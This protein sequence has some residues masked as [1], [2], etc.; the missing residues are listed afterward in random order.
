MTAPECDVC[1]VGAGVAGALVAYALGRAGISTVVLEAGRR[2]PVEDRPRYMARQLDWDDPWR[3]DAP[4]RDVYTR[5]GGVEYDLN[6]YRVKAVGGSTMHWVGYT[7]RFHADDFAMRTR[8]GVAEDWPVRYVDLEPWYCEAEAELAVAGTESPFASP[9]SCPYP[10][11]AFPVGYDEGLLVQAGRRIGIDFHP[12]PQARNSAPYDGRPQC[13]TFGTC[14]TCPIRVR[15]SADVHVEL[16]EA[17]GRVTVI[18]ESTVVRL[19]TGGVNGGAGA[20][21]VRRAI[22][23]ASDGTEHACE[24]EAFVVAAHAVESARLLLL[25]AQPG[26]PDGLANGSGTAGR[27]FMEHM[28]QFRMAELDRNLHPHRKGFATVFSQQY[29][30][31]STRD[32]ESGFLLRDNAEGPTLDALLRSTIGRSGNWGRA[33]ESELESVVRDR[34]GRTFL[35]GSNAEPLPSPEN[36]VE[37]D[38]EVRVCFGNPAPRITYAISDYERTAYR[39]ADPIIHALADELGARSLGDMQNHFGGHQAGTCRM[40]DDPDASVVDRQL[41][42]HEVENLYVVGSGNFVT[43]S[44]VNP[45][46]T[47]A[48]L[49]LRL[50][51]HLG[52]K[53]GARRRTA[54]RVAPATSPRTATEPRASQSGAPLHGAA[55]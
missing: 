48:A 33:L 29:H 32:R 19:E 7:P 31:H 40:G 39:R 12:I 4:R 11:E 26:H 49:A 14:R 30:N 24:A 9:R 46:L 44:V 6:R 15:Y 38:S 10:L 55:R 2:H 13:V 47:I 1:I 25:S 42:A 27:F 22:Y 51:A 35:I 20:G 50:G 18:P 16:A 34:F 8:F 52:G 45:T 43:L 21:R 23:V 54:R 53:V 36:R 28:G 41:K 37:L 5:G 3:T 17:T